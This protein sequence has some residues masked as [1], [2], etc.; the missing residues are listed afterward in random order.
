MPRR[1]VAVATILT[2]IVAVTAIALVV[3][4]SLARPGDAPPGPLAPLPTIRPGAAV[5]V[6][7]GDIS[8][9]DNDHDEATARLIEGIPGTVFTT[10]DNAYERGTE[11]EYLRCFDPT[12]GRFRERIRPVPGNHEYDTP[13]ASGYRAYFGAAAGEPGRSWYA[14]DVGGWRIYALD[15]NC[16]RVG[17]C[18]AGSPQM[19]WLE[20][21]LATNP[22][23]CVAAMWHHPLFSSGRHGDATF[24]RP[25]WKVLHAAGAE[26]ILNGHEHQYERLAPQDP[27]GRADPAT[28]V[29]QFTVGTGGKSLYRFTRERD[30]SEARDDRTYGVLRLSLWDGGY[31]WAFV[32]AAPGTFTDSGSG[33]CH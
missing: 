8:T 2:A 19:T 21:D 3:A 20:A 6:G 23:R 25:L 11:D 29:R 33:A 30:T 22:R 10:G 28:G 24:M 14:F 31:D 26:V 17:G 16:D 27:D 1:A 15:S 5:F 9:C 32:P 13:N 12:W 4:S 7:T 18:G